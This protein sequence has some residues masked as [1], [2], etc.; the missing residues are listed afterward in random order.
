MGGAKLALSRYM[1]TKIIRENGHLVLEGRE[2]TEELRTALIHLRTHFLSECQRRDLGTP[3][4]TLIPD[5]TVLAPAKRGRPARSVRD[6]ELPAI[7][8]GPSLGD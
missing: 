4:E 6:V 7:P 5:I 2:T 8:K 3:I 1:M